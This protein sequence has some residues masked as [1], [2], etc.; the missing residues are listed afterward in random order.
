ME[1]EQPCRLTPDEWQL[2]K[3]EA[4]FIAAY[5]GHSYNDAYKLAEE[6]I[7]KAVGKEIK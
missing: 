6:Y 5:R 4:E 3:D 7:R 1:S 2:V